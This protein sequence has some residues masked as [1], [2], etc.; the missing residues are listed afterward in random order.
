MLKAIRRLIAKNHRKRAE[1]LASER[2]FK[3][4]VLCHDPLEVEAYTPPG[5]HTRVLYYHY[6]LAEE[7]DFGVVGVWRSISKFTGSELE[8]CD[9]M[10]RNCEN[11]S[12][13]EI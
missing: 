10:D 6:T 11:A 7:R 9:L 5:T 13:W 12:F 4:R 8:R 1:R 3:I 2:G